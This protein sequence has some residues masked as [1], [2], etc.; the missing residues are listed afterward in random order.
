MARIDKIF[1]NILAQVSKQDWEEAVRPKWSDGEPVKVKRILSISND[2]D[3]S[4]EFPLASL[5]PVNLKGCVREAIWIWAKRSV[6]T[7][8]LGLHIWDAWADKD[9]NIS[10]C[11]GDMVNRPIIISKEYR[12]GLTPISLDR[13][14][15]ELVK[16]DLINLPCGSSNQIHRVVGYG[17]TNQTDFILWSLKN[18]PSSRRILG[19]MFCPVT[20]A[21]KPLEECAF[22]INCSVKDGKLNMTLYQRSCDLITAFLWNTAQYAALLMMF[23]HDAGLKPGVFTHFIQDA[24]VYDRHEKQMEELLHRSLFG[25]IPQV[26]ISERMADKGFYDFTP[27]DFEVWNYEPKEQIKFEVA[28]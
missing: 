15:P 19:S 4:R 14:V 22:Q 17:F 12:E 28:V 2:Y 10:G 1:Q 23:A 27:E 6:S 25:P 5:R 24:H 26:T 18:D 13:C 20:N 8:E 21:I 11:Y 3:L 7:T 16:E 9:G